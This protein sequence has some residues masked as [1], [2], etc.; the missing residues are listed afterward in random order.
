[1]ALSGQEIEII[2]PNK[3]TKKIRE[4]AQKVFRKKYLSENKCNLMKLFGPRP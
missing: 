4:I 3:T 2:W 1:M